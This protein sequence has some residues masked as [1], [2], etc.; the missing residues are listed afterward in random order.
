MIEKRVLPV[1]V[2]F[3]V[4]VCMWFL[5]VVT[6]NVALEHTGWTFIVLA[7]FSGIAFDSGTRFLDAAREENEH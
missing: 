7:L 2:T 6:A 5:V 1:P 3:I 4:M